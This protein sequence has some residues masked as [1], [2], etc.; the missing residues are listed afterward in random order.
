VATATMALMAVSVVIRTAHCVGRVVI[1]WAITVLPT[2]V[3]PEEAN[4]GTAVT[5]ITNAL[6]A[7]EAVG[8]SITTLAIIALRFG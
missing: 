7:V 5:T 2:T 1:A 3:L 6:M 8:V 4:I